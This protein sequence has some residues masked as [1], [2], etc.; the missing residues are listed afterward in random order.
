MKLYN[1]DNAEGF[2][3]R[4]LRCSGDVYGVDAVG[5]RTDLKKM[6]EY[7]IHSGA[8]KSLRGIDEIDVR[9]E[10]DSDAMDMMR[11][12]M[13]MNRPDRRPLSA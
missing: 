10:K 13:E 11:F 12:A 8:A 2:F 9:V 1:I 7:C 6:A 3:K 5:R 4:V